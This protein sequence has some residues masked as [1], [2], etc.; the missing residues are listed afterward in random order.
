MKAE[1]KEEPETENEQIRPKMLGY[2]LKHK[3]ISLLESIKEEEE[4]SKKE[5]RVV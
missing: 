1:P 2:H 4:K 5:S 3:V